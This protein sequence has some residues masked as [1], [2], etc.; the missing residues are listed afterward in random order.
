M[1]FYETFLGFTIVVVD[2]F[3]ILLPGAACR[4]I[5]GTYIRRAKSRF[6]CKKVAW[7]T[8]ARNTCLAISPF[9]YFARS[10][11]WFRQA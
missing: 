1:F 3:I 6:G 11:L 7:F 8:L 4:S 10:F 9:E 5:F 2:I